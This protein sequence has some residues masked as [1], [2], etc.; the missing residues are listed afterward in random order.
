[1]EKSLTP[2]SRMNA[3]ES[4]GDPSQ[5]RKNSYKLAEFRSK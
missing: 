4:G 3:S 1:M 5:M 2:I